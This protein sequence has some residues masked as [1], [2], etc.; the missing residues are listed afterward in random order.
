MSDAGRLFVIDTGR[1]L[2]DVYVWRSEK[3]G[4]QE[5]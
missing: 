3:T 5:V 4:R 2:V 1:L